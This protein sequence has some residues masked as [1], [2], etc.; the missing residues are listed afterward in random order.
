MQ[1]F[2]IE[3]ISSNTK[4]PLEGA[5]FV[6]EGSK[7]EIRLTTDKDGKASVDLPYGEYEL[8]E[9]VAPDG[10]VLERRVHKITV[11]ENGITMNGRTLQKQTVV[12]ENHPVEIPVVIHKQDS[13]SRNALKGA[14]F[15][16]TGKNFEQT[17]ETDKHGN[18][19]KIFL[20]PGEYK[21]TETT[22][23]Q[24]YQ[25]P[26]TSWVLKVTRDGRVCSVGSFAIESSECGLVTI[27]LENSKLTYSGG[28]SGSGG[29][30]SS[31]ITKTGQTFDQ[32]LFRAGV[33]MT[34]ASAAGL[35]M[36]L[37]DDIRRRRR[38]KA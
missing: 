8:R 15:K 32:S 36:L 17:L 12:I 10:Y 23:P 30:V 16:I 14:K 29:S 3:K 13:C 11:S 9:V 35:I 22:A 33:A 21:I 26:L 24:G 27:V 34:T 19:Q 25:K 37:L 18:T 31:T 2:I 7:T 28:G 20:K 4:K 6:I 38:Q 1:K 5:T